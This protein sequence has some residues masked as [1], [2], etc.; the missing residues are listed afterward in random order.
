VPC[1]DALRGAELTAVLGGVTLDLRNALPA[2]EGATV[3]A[4]AVFGGLEL[5]HDE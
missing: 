5:K 1:T 2:P 3:T 4:T